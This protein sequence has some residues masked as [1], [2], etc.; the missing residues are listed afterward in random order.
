MR[1]GSPAGSIVTTKGAIVDTI[2]FATDGSPS[3]RKAL[4]EAIELAQET[5]WKLRVLTVWQMPLVTGY[6][7]A[8]AAYVPE[9]AETEKEHA[10]Q[11]AHAAVAV[12]AR[13]GVAATAEIREGLAADEIC[14]AAAEE[15]ARLIVMGAHGWGAIKRVLFGSV[16]THVLHDAPC[17][18]LIVRMSES[19][20]ERERGQAAAAVGV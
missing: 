1:V 13:A 10:A 19:E 11:V 5:G 9:L 20:L 15:G 7:F 8:P 16:S 17:P 6:G 12:A 18:V 14:T 2:L 3:A 4:G